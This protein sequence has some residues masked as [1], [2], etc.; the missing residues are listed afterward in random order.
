MGPQS[1][2]GREISRTREGE[3]VHNRAAQL[4]RHVHP[5]VPREGGAAAA[6]TAPEPGPHEAPPPWRPCRGPSADLSLGA[7]AGGSASEPVWPRHLRG[8]LSV[9]DAA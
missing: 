6:E 9:E 1:P 2:V 3:L 5:S 4:W 8:G 7:E